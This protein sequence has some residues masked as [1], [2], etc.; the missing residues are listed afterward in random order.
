MS[1]P[2]KTTVVRNVFSASNFAAANASS[3]LL[4]QPLVSPLHHRF[5]D[6]KLRGGT[7]LNP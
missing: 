4:R 7:L 5:E 2:P 6:T 1:A 3:K